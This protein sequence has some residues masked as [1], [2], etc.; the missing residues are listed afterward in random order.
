MKTYARPR[1]ELRTTFVRGRQGTPIRLFPLVMILTQK[2]MNPF[3]RLRR[4]IDL[5][6]IAPCVLG[7][8]TLLVCACC[9]GCY[10]GDDLVKRARSA[11]L[12]TRL[13]EVDLGTFQTTLP[14]N[15]LSSALTELEVHV[16]GTVPRYRVPAIETQLKTEEFRLRH[17]MLAAIR[18]TTQEELTEPSLIGMRSRIGTVVN[19]VLADAPVKTIGFYEISVR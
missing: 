16:F 5:A 9:A 10:D 4:A 1:R 19:G 18:T 8:S 11:A 2:P 17:E 3:H 15:S 7:V 14:G 6:N 12:T 13:A